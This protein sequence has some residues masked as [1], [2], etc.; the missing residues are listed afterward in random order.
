MEEVKDYH[1][2]TIPENKCNHSRE[3][4]ASDGVYFRVIDTY[5]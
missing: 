5:G 4:C 1:E 3:Q 2:P